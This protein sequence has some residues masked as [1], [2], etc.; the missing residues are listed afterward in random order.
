[1]GFRERKEQ[2]PVLGAHGLK[3][4]TASGFSLLA[5]E[6]F[7]APREIRNSFP[8]EEHAR[9]CDR[10]HGLQGHE[11]PQISFLEEG[12]QSLLVT[13]V[14]STHTYYVPVV[15]PGHYAF[16][17]S[18]DM[19]SKMRQNQFLKNPPLHQTYLCIAAGHLNLCNLPRV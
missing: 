10:C 6:G 5:E 15:R 1:M 19:V 12:S 14:G 11:T 9:R 18:E 8:K 17:I 13:S 7:W 2:T 16:P 4:R 3:E